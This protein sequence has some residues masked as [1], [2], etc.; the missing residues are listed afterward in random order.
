M[1]EETTQIGLDDVLITQELAHRS[2]RTP[3][4]Q[5]EIDAQHTLARQLA[6]Q[7]QTML[8]TLVTVALELCGAGSAG[9]SLLEVTP[10]GEEVFRWVALAGALEAY[11][12]GTVERYK[13]PCGVCLE[14]QAPQLYSYPGRY[15]TDLQDIQPQIVEALVIP[16]VPGNQ[17][18]GAI[19]GDVVKVLIRH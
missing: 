19:W 15:F 1:P 11:E 4:L 14:A 16:L 7:S 9:V 8:K 18:L 5:A 2:P 6:E 12:Q 17:P 3:N 13:S 10:N